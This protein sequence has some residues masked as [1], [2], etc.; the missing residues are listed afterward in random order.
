M[1]SQ[2]ISSPGANVRLAVIETGNK[3]PGKSGIKKQARGVY[4]LF[5]RTSQARI[6][7][8]K[9]NMLYILVVSG[10]IALILGRMTET[11]ADPDLWGYMAFGRLFWSH[12]GFPYHDPYAYTPTKAF[13]VYHEW[14]TGVIFYPLYKYLGTAGLQ[15]L[16]YIIGL[17]TAFIIYRTARVR[18]A[19]E[20]ASVIWL[21]LISPLFSFA[22]SP[23]R[24]Q[25]FTHFFFALTL[26]ILEHTKAA[27]DRCNLWWLLPIFLLWSNLHGGFIAGIGLVGI[28]AAGETLSRH[29]VLPYW[30]ILMPV[31]LVTLINP[32]GPQ[33]WTYLKDALL[34][35]RPDIDEW[36]S[37]FFALKNGEYI[38]NHV[39]FLVLILLACLMLITSRVRRLSDAALMV[40][41]GLLAF[42]H[43]RHE[44]LFFITM[45][46]C[47]PTYFT[48]A[49]NAFGSPEVRADFRNKWTKVIAPILFFL[50]LI[51]FGARFVMGHPF[52]LTLRSSGEDKRADYNYPVGAIQYLHT[53]NMKGNILTEFSWGEYVIWNM[54]QNRV[55][56]DGRY[57]TL[58]TEETTREYFQFTRG[59]HGWQDYLNKYP[60]DM[61][62][63]R[64][65]STVN[66]L[67]R[68]HPQWVQVYS[69]TDCLLF[70][71]RK[72]SP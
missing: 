59:E 69:D 54:P 24:A 35:P 48:Q 41:T 52:D 43:V 11:M 60:H 22:Y 34:M 56:M 68:S 21:L 51:I 29:K 47:G 42:Q 15:G 64:P 31:V 55:A 27:G 45:G 50:L 9:I 36:H 10:T 20:E 65:D 2:V 19:S 18:G 70:I 66:T 32:Y 37:V 67:L 13:W 5:L 61:I 28:F 17:A 58:Y 7:P 3:Y 49:W 46:C 62:L 33:Y 30:L 72:I 25:V 14:L 40:V 63:F 16:K 12:A 38:A 8:F 26:Y 23:V 71:R 4:S 53:H 44:S 39:I 57:E 1:K 6:I